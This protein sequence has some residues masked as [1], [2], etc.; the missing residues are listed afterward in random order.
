MVASRATLRSLLADVD[1]TA[2][3]ADPDALAFALEDLALLDVLEELAIA[4]FM[5]LLDRGDV[6]EETGDI[7]ESLGLGL[8]GEIPDNDLEVDDEFFFTDE[9]YQGY[10]DNLEEYDL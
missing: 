7:A 4:L 9:D 3:A 8:F 6:A 10:L 1:M 2:V 5:A